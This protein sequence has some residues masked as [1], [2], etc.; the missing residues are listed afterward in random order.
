MELKENMVS[1]ISDNFN[2]Y[3]L[4]MDL[5]KAGED[6]SD[7][8]SAINDS[9]DIN[10]AILEAKFDTSKEEINDYINKRNEIIKSYIEV[11]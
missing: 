5:F 4:A 10:L 3:N 11:K 1:K 7:L 6:V 8:M 9:F 2:A